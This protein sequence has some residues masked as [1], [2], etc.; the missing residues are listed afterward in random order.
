LEVTLQMAGSPAVPTSLTGLP[1]ATTT[2]GTLVTLISDSITNI[3][4]TQQQA[5]G[6]TPFNLKGMGRILKS[7]ATPPN[8]PSTQADIANLVLPPAERVSGTLD[9]SVATGYF[10]DSGFMYGSGTNY[11]LTSAQYAAL[12]SAKLDLALISLISAIVASSA[13]STVSS[14]SAKAALLTKL[15]S[16][17]Q[18]LNLDKLSAITISAAVNNTFNHLSGSALAAFGLPGTFTGTGENAVINEGRYLVYRTGIYADLNGNWTENSALAKDLGLQEITYRIE[19]NDYSWSAKAFT[20]WVNDNFM[21]NGDYIMDSATMKN[22]GYTTGTLPTGFNVSSCGP[23]MGSATD[24]ATASALLVYNAHKA[25][26]DKYP[27]PMD[28]IITTSGA[29]LTTNLHDIS[30]AQITKNGTAT[31]T[32]G[33]GAGDHI[34]DGQTLAINTGI[35][36]QT[37]TNG[38]WTESAS[39]AASLGFEELV[40]S[41]TNTTGTGVYT[42]AA[43][44]TGGAVV[45][46]NGTPALTA[47]MT[48]EQLRAWTTTVTRNTISNIGTNA[49]VSTNGHLV[50]TA[51]TAAE[52]DA[53]K[54]VP[55]PGITYTATAETTNTFDPALA[56]Y[57]QTTAYVGGSALIR[58]NGNP[59]QGQPVTSTMRNLATA[60]NADIE[61]MLGSFQANNN[62]LPG[63]LFKG[64]STKPNGPE[65]LSEIVDLLTTDTYKAASSQQTITTTGIIDKTKHATLVASAGTAYTN[66][67]GI[68]NFGAYALA[69]AI[70]HNANSQFWAMVQ[71]HD[72]NGN[73]ADMVYIFKKDGGDF[74]DLLACDVADGD[75]ASQD[76][77]LAIEFENTETGRINQDGTNFTLGGQAWGTFKPVQTKAGMGKEVWNLTLHGRDVGRERDLWIAAVTDGKN[78]LTTPGLNGDIINGLDRHSFVEIQNADNGEWAGAEVRTQSSAQEA[79]DA[80][81]GAMERK[82]KVRADIGALQNRLENTITNL[83]IQVEALQASE[84]RISDID[85][86]TEMTEFVRNQVLAQAAVS[87]LSQA[88][89]LPQMALSLLN[90]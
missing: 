16:M 28:K 44:L 20:G 53:A 89:S 29:N 24:A 9:K 32:T 27:T 37:N 31:I 80:L 82:D 26:A 81:N 38:I 83:E 15:T 10:A 45:T 22:L 75:I 79:L 48:L 56:G 57:L 21:E 50:P 1:K 41:V 58:L 8:G 17:W 64:A 42:A 68:S 5:A 33:D 35:Y 30:L 87:M 36:L 55:P 43:A 49:M 65:N 25:W 18:A 40:I 11:G 84:S 12:V 51:P 47:D 3:L 72:S 54:A 19:N 60:I 76:A 88:N 59:P 7:Q 90:G 2:I 67:S 23:F 62:F 85:V 13:S 4:L 6:T 73:S 78:E 14:A 66:A 74:N 52:L 46:L 34:I 61:L 77:K 63:K 39:L 70:N 71:N 86:A 69:S